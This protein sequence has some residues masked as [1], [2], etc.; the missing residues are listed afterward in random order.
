M[1]TLKTQL[2]KYVIAI[3]S[4]NE[5]KYYSGFDNK[6]K[7]RATDNPGASTYFD[8]EDSAKNFSKTVKAIIDDENIKLEVRKIVIKQEIEI[9]E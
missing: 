1:K 2:E 6:M 7:P 4:D 9:Y 5:E 3:V 8:T